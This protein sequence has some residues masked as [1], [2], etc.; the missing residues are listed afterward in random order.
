MGKLDFNG[1]CSPW[2][3]VLHR[4]LR[5][6]LFPVAC[7]LQSSS[8]DFKLNFPTPQSSAKLSRTVTKLTWNTSASVTIAW[9]LR[10]G[11]D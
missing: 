8:L 3:R 7:D 9:R 1:L 2:E 4:P 6:L 11:P 10:Q 5:L